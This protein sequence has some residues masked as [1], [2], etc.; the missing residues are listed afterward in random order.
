MFLD[1]EV[2]LAFPSIGTGKFGVGRLNPNT[3]KSIT[4]GCV[5]I[6]HTCT[7]SLGPTKGAVTAT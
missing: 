3:G 7:F 1:G 2:G 6:P 4:L 5:R